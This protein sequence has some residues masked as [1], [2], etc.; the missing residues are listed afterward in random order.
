MTM[1]TAIAK[2]A[3]PQPNACIM[4]T[5]NA[6]RTLTLT[7]FAAATITATADTAPVPLVQQ[8]FPGVPASWFQSRQSKDYSPITLDAAR[9]Y[10]NPNA[11]EVTF[12]A[13][14]APA[15]A[16]NTANYTVAPGVSVTAA[17]L[18]SN[19]FTVVLTTAA[20]PDAGLHTLAATNIF[21]ATLQYSISPTLLPILKAQGV[22]TRKLFTGITGAAVSNLTSAAKFPSAPD[23]VDW[24]GAFEANANA[25]DNYGLQF[26]GYVHPPATGDYAFFIAADEQAALYLSP[27][28]N[29]ANKALIANVPAATAART[30]T[31]YTNQRSAYVRLEAGRAYYVEALLKESTGSDHLAVTWRLRGMSAPAAGDAPIPGAFLSSLTPSAPVSIT[32]QPQAQTVAERAPAAFAVVPTGT[33]PYTYQ[34]LRNG[35]PIPGATATNYTIVSAPYSLSGSAFAVVVANAFSSITSSPAL[36]TVTA[37]TSPPTIVRLDG[38][39]TLDRATVSFSE[40]VTTA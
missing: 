29:P 33:P 36:L 12:S 10:G 24:P 31:T 3:A 5:I 22:I 23:A 18:G 38:S 6:L 35:T 19:A 2:S 30:Y 32:A 4:K 27:D 37:D 39:A 1:T 15:T 9:T 28:A 16:T 14:V 25:A 34:W 21:D 7:A 20:I 17:R 13:P 8:A 26:A 40:P 11:I